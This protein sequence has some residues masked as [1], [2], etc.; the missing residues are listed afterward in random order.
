MAISAVASSSEAQASQGAPAKTF[1]AR[2]VEELDP[3]E[4]SS[5]ENQSPVWRAASVAVIVFFIAISV[6]AVILV[7]I[8]APAY[9]PLSAAPALI[10][11]NP[12]YQ[13]Y[14]K[15]E[16]YADEAKNIADKLTAIKREYEHLTTLSEA[17]VQAILVQ[18]SIPVPDAQT[19]TA[20]KPLI[21][22][23]LFWERHT[24]LS[25]QKHQEALDEAQKVA[26]RT[27][28]AERNDICAE[29]LKAL[30]LE[31][32]VLQC[33]VQN[34][35]INAVIRNPSSTASFEESGTFSP[36]SIQQRLLGNAVG[37]PTAT[38]F[39]TLKDRTVIPI[40]DVRRLTISELGQRIVAAMAA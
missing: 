13:L 37:D 29:Q 27:P 7:G 1:L 15:C 12:A 20:I 35:F 33:K 16:R 30:E 6:T 9:I 21:A 4:I 5:Y 36:L 11:L 24:A 18:R 34:A 39:F 19:L 28:P 38:P 3:K 2:C 26:A 40:D 14:E 23:H 22:H 25:A 10:L 31:N 32:Y 8:Y 17:E